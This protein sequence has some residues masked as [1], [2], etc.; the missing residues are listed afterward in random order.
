MSEAVRRAITASSSCIDEM[1]L[2]QTIKRFW[3]VALLAVGAQ[4][5]W[6]FALLGPLANGGDSWQTGTIGYGLLYTEYLYP[7]G[8]VNLGD[9]GG[10]KNL[11]E[12][13]R[14]N[15]PVIYYTYDANFLDYFGS[16][17]VAAVDSAFAI[18]NQAFTTNPMTGEYLTNGVDSFSDDLSEYPPESLHINYEAQ[19]LAL[20]DLKSVTLHA[21]VE[22]LGLAE[23]E[24]FTWTLAERIAPPGCPFT[25]LYLVVQRNY[26]VS[27]SLFNQVQYSSYVNDTLYT[28]YILEICSGPSPLAITVPYNVDPYADVFTAVAANNA[29]GLGI[30][31]Y[32]TGLTRDDM[33]GLRYLYSAN[34]RNWETAAFIGQNGPALTSSAGNSGIGAA[35]LLVTNA[36]PQQIIT[37]Q[38]LGPLLAAA[39][40]D[41][42]AT[43]QALFPGLVIAS[44]SN[45][46]SL[47]IETN[48]FAYYTNQPG[49]DVTNYAGSQIL[50]SQ[51]FGLLLARAATNDPATLESFY[52]DLMVSTV[53]N[54]YAVS[55]TTNITASYT[56]QPGPSLTNFL[57][58][59]STNATLDFGLLLQ[60]AAADDPATLVALYP[61]LVVATTTNLAAVITTNITAY[62]TNQPGPD[63]TNYLKL[64]STNTTSNLGL[65][66]QQAAADDPA[67]LQALNPGLV[68]STVTNDASVILVTNVTA[69]YTNQP[70]PDVTNYLKLFSTNTTS[71]LGLLLQQ[72]AADDPATLQ[73]LNPGLVFSTVT[74][75]ATVVITTNITA[76]YTNQ[77]GLDVTNFLPLYLTNATSDYGLLLQRAATNDP[78][79]LQA[80]YPGL[81]FSTV[82]ND[83]VVVV[84]TNI[85]AYYTNQPYIAGPGTN[86]TT[87]TNFQRLFIT[88]ATSD[89]GLLLQR[90][91]TNDPATLQA[92]YPGL[93]FSTVTNDPVVVYTTNI[94]AYY[95]N[96][97]YLAG[98]GTN[99]T[100]VTNFQRLFITNATSDYGLLLRA[101]TNDPAT[102]QALY[103]GLLFSTITNDPVVVYTTNITAYYTNQPYIPGP[104]T[105]AT[106]VTNWGDMQISVPPPSAANGGTLDFGLFTMQALT[107]STPGNNPA[108]AIAQLQALYPGLVIVSAT[109]YPTNVVTTNFI[110][111]FVNPV[112]EPVGSPQ[113]QVTSI[114]SIVTN[115]VIRYNYVFGNLLIDSNSSGVFYP[116]VSYAASAGLYSTNQYVTTQ[117]TIMAPRIGAPVGSPSATNVYTKTVQQYGIGGDFFIVPTNWCG[118]TILTNAAY[119]EDPIL[120]WMPSYTNLVSAGFTNASAGTNTG[121]LYATNIEI[122]YSYTNVQY[123]IEP[124]ICEPLLQFATNVT[125]NVV[126]TYLNTPLNVYIYTNSLTSQETVITNMV[127]TTNTAPWGILYTNAGT[128]VITLTNV[129][130][131]DYFLVPT[132][133][134]WVQV[135]SNLL[136]GVVYYTN[137]TL[138]AGPAPI[139]AAPGGVLS[140]VAE[141]YSQ[142]VITSFTNHVLRIRQ[143]ICEPIL[144]FATNVTANVVITYSNTLVNVYVYTNSATSQETVLTTNIFTTNG[145]LVGT[146]FTNSPPLPPSG[147]TN[148]VGTTNITV[149]MPTGDYFLI[150]TNWCG[151]QIVSNLLTSVVYTTNT[152]FALQTPLVG[153]PGQVESYSQTVITAFT[154]HNLVMRQGICEPLLQFFTNYTTNVVITYSNTLVNVYV[155]TN[156]ATSQETVLTTNIFTTNGALV[157]TLFTNSPPLPPS[158]PTN[159]GTTNITVS[160]PTGDYFLIPTNWCGFQ[161]VSNLLTSVVYYTNTMFALQTPLVGAPGQVE[162]FS[163]SVITTF[164][165]H[166]LVI[167]QGICEPILQFSTNYTT[168]V[169]ITYQNTLLNVY[170]NSYTNISYATVLTTNIFTTNGALLGTLFTN[171]PPPPPSGPTNLGA[172]VITL[173][174]VPTG[175][176]F[177]IPTNWCGVTIVSTQLTSV[178]YTTNS[179]FALQTPL[180]GAPGLVESFSQS[181]ITTFTNHNLVIRQ[182]I[183]EPIL[184]FAT[185]VTTNVVITYQNTL[186]NVYTNSYTN[187]SYATVLTTNI[188]TTN[189]ALLGTLFTNSPPLPPS[190]PT[191]LGMS[192]IALTNVPTGDY[193][194]IPTNWCGVTIVSTQLTSVVYTTNS[195]F[196]LQTP[197]VGAPGLVESFSQSVITTF[198]NH[199]LVIRQAICEPILQFVTNY[200]TNVVITYSNTLMNIYTNTYSATSQETVL[201]TNIFTTNGALVGTLFTNSPPLP[202]SGPTNLGTSVITTDV[203]AGDFLIIPTN[204]CWFRIVT[205]SGTL[206]SNLLTTVVY[207]T[208]TTFALQTPLVGA[209][210]VES[211]SQ[212]VI[213][214][215][216]NHNL[217]IQQGIC[218]PEL[219]FYTNYTTNVLIS[220]QNTLLNVYTNYYAPTS[221]VTV[222]VT[223]IGTT[224][225]ALVGTLV[226]NSPLSVTL[227]TNLPTGDFFIVPTNWCGFRFITSSNG[228]L[229]NVVYQTNTILTATI[230]PGMAN[231]GQQYSQTLYGQYTNHTFIIQ[232]GFCI[233]TLVFGTNYTTNIVTTYQYTFANVYTNFYAPTSTVTVV[234]TNIYATNGSLFGI[235]KT[236]VGSTNYDVD[237]PTGDFFIIPANWCSFSI[238]AT[239]LTNVSYATNFSIA[240]ATTILTITNTI[241][242][243]G[244]STNSTVSVSTNVQQYSVSIYASSTN[245]TFLIQPEACSLVPFATGLRPGIERVQFVKAS[246]DSLLG[247]TFQPITNYYTMQLI[248]NSQVVTQFFQ[249]VVLAPDILLTAANDIAANT[250]DGSIVRNIVF[251]EDN[252]GAGLAGPGTI[253]P[254]T[255]ISYNKVGNAYENGFPFTALGTNVFVLEASQMP[256]LQWASFDAST[257]DPV[258]YPDGDSIANME[259]QVLIQVLPPP[260]TLPDGATNAAYASTFSVANGTGGAF[261]PPFTWGL[262]SGSLPAG[263]YW[264]NSL[265]GAPND[266]IAGTPPLQAGTFD[267]TVQLTDSLGRSV[268]WNYTITI[269]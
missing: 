151:F 231:I 105:N 68:F 7:G 144:Q 195:A 137:T 131:G 60:R 24:R 138:T 63:V 84:T 187:I 119:D 250:F 99:A 209:P 79:T 263:L 92:L 202:P 233:F 53:T 13:Y 146:L 206:D 238:V 179:A 121:S 33:A 201:T 217:V 27:D 16:N 51:D 147:P 262:A 17:G 165:N 61:G 225:G 43:L 98:P 21:L 181:V 184:Q 264:T 197:L 127:F 205:N 175:D 214:A 249:R 132:N 28:Y 26:P 234:T 45:T 211:F 125:T 73:A 5:A 72:A 12:E 86:A 102:L 100:T 38:P 259:K 123:V 124:G 134:C 106:T 141:S 70:G 116:F 188:F 164:T 236:N 168:N 2:L 118:F 149:S 66:L 19:S 3:W 266:T 126:I 140:G 173:T 203:P 129:P 176:Y 248:N 185:N 268:N 143:G 256:V 113:I 171:S 80:L 150:P 251:D 29:D 252:I 48:Y 243:N 54:E 107:N 182:G 136:T 218:E 166:N 50:V 208:N 78:A 47:S 75:D 145:A 267:F 198:T 216:T 36:L 148:L 180:V 122:I 229:T 220:F 178:V 67:T 4:P 241:Y 62:Y 85:G 154:N 230:P 35:N 8:P 59:L 57:P 25:T 111:T 227:V 190:G 200:T 77:P 120:E 91:A 142:T 152:M 232:P 239:L 261:T 133:W 186:L 212:T 88:N 160:V 215:F 64:F 55:V 56:N 93:V 221:T 41:D 89:Y 9:I 172:S 156:S 39:E 128:N 269:H 20:T 49:P 194:L 104:G 103:P 258:V 192:V 22:Q 204:W 226:T 130:T 46:L 245:H 161:I 253:N 96:Q 97:P 114:G 42:P 40:V 174:N 240:T 260:P 193:F 71:N 76:Y 207:T 255:T 82:T 108:T 244:I 14:R 81:V 74:N 11:A 95:T 191:N 112:G 15:T 87:V 52:P 210:G 110:T 44:S 223:N 169:V 83:P 189:G 115:R 90:A 235:L 162:S 10:P 237:L 170:T 101:M 247:R 37:T 1:N 69:Y 157:G 177:L 65:L 196:A 158:G 153:A 94:T 222:V 219:I 254:R 31:G 167:R 246:Y 257:N 228:V 242:T 183:C 224:N 135:V 58:T 34:N 32:Y 18:I 109:G 6:G 155:Y 265:P 213:T 23:P 199:N 139:F 117:T 159:L 163:Q 30:G